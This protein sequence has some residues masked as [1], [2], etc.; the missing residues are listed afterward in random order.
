MQQER[1]RPTT[2]PAAQRRSNLTLPTFTQ[3][4]SARRSKTNLLAG[5]GLGYDFS[6]GLGVLVEYEYY[7]KVG[8]SFSYS[9][10]DGIQ[11][12]GQANMNLFTVSGMIRF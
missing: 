8:S 10:T 4:S 2:S 3:G 6:N 11:G 1:C 9:P 12:T 5:A 7:G